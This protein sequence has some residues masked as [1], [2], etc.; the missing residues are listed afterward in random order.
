MITSRQNS[1][2]KEIKSLSLKK[3]RD[4]TG[5]FLVEGVKS[6]KEAVSCGIKVRDLI[7]TERGKELFGNCILPF[8]TVT[9]G[10]F[11]AITDDK[12]P[13]GVLAVCHIPK[14]SETDT[15]CKSVFLDGVSD[16]ANVGAIIRSA[17]AFGYGT[18][19]IADGADAYSA[20]SVRASMGGI[21]RVK[22]FSGKREELLAKVKV[23]ILVADMDGKDIRSVKI[24]P[25]H[26]IAVG[27]EGHG[28]SKEVKAAG[29][30]IISIPMQNGVESLNAAVSASIIMYELNK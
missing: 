12:T 1:L 15:D 21:F 22:V 23:P 2:I 6:V 28:V 29:Q 18:V 9:D 14:F 24:A 30:E 3:Y 27:N 11:D 8:E 25:A 26:C 5:L 4:E 13:Q 7:F 19:F 17:A 20:K 10:V 16:P